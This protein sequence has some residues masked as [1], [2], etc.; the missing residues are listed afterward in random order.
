METKK[1]N[2]TS[3]PQKKGGKD[4]TKVILTAAGAA[5][6]GA[7]GVLAAQE[8]LGKDRLDDDLDDLEFDD[9]ET[10]IAPQQETHAAAPQQPAA[11]ASQ[12]ANVN[13]EEIQPVDQAPVETP[14]N[15]TVN[16]E[17]ESPQ[18][19]QVPEEV[20]NVDPDAIA[21][22]ITAVQVDP[23]DVDL[24]DMIQVDGVETMY[25][26]DGSEMPVALVHTPDNGQY[27]MIDVD[28][29]LTFDVITDLEGNP[30]V[31]VD[32]NLT[33][34]DVEDMIDETG[35][36][37]A[38]NADQNDRELAHGENPE[39][40]IVNTEA[41]GDVAINDGDDSEYEEED[42]YDDDLADAD[43]DDGVMTDDLA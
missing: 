5:S 19:P 24:A 41:M 16:T 38:Y 23:N 26:N 7:G 3:T 10:V 42:G 35:D 8:L 15:D 13:H 21:Q 37:L 29:D 4:V 9:N 18:Q 43:Y 31:A 25:F 36:A 22:E 2:F 28:N 11:P 6:V 20:E 39:A 12:P 32:S 40:D 34:S 17:P 14:T 1:N 27:L 33:M 30:I